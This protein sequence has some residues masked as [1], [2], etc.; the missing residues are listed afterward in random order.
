[1]IAQQ[2]LT[3]ANAVTFLRVA[4]TP[5]IILAIVHGHHRAA[6]VWFAIAAWTDFFDGWLARSQGTPSPVG[7]YF[8]PL[9]DKL[10]ISGVF[11]ALTIEGSIPVWFL[12][13]V[14]GRDLAIVIASIIAMRVSTYRD[15]SP[16]VWGKLSTVLQLFAAV[17]VM[18]ANAEGSG[19]WASLA[20]FTVFAAAAGT[21]WSTIHYTWRG[22]TYFTR[23]HTHF[24]AR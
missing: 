11:I 15:Y 14:L 19:T 5:V 12:G 10:L 3:P 18:A 8:D 17:T 24:P 21:V 6:A 22:V 7:Q 9:A 4:L 16:T 2:W 13:L 23:P 1:M 20:R